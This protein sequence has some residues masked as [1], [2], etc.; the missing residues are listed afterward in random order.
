MGNSSLGG[1]ITEFILLV[2]RSE[3]RAGHEEGG[4]SWWRILALENQSVYTIRL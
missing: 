4:I 1:G 2:S 3:A